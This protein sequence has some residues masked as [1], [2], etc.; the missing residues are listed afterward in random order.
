MR[1][2]KEIIEKIN[3]LLKVQSN[4]YR[5]QDIL[6]LTKVNKTIRETNLMRDMLEW[7]LNEIGE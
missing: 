2:E 4:T 5:C 1:T 6:G 7:V 3:E